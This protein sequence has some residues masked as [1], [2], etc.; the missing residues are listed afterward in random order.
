MGP[1]ALARGNRKA[2]DRPGQG[3]QASMGP[4]ALARGN[5]V[6]TKATIWSRPSFNGAA[7]SRARKYALALFDTF[8]V[9]LLQW[10]RALSRA[11]IT[12]AV[13]VPSV[14][15]WLQW[16]RALSRAEIRPSADT[17]T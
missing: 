14:I 13:F 2:P 8:D 12:V 7:R 5:I 6:T 1:R 15:C 9:V 4:R 10:G 3:R 11:E 17:F 16:G